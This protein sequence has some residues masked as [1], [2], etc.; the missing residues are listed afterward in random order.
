MGIQSLVVSAGGG[1]V[2]IM[3][4][5]P[6]RVKVVQVDWRVR[7]IR[8]TS[9][10]RRN[11][12]RRHSRGLRIEGEESAG[13]RSVVAGAQSGEIMEKSKMNFRGQKSKAD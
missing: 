7:E 1:S 13:R 9:C 8:Q 6:G 12:M 5:G 2:E 11:C 10:G 3:L 4:I